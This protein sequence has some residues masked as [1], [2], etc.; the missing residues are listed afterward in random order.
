MVV[1]NT[2]SNKE[3]PYQNIRR[4][5][6]G[7]KIIIKKESVSVYPIFIHLLHAF[8]ALS[9]E[10]YEKA[11]KLNPNMRKYAH[12]LLEYGKSKR[13]TETMTNVFIKWREL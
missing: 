4:G 12:E 5:V 9:M 2:F 10:E 8:L 7:Q 3:S 1:A 6:K 13:E 11:K